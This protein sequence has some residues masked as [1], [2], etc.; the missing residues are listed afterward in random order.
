MVCCFQLFVCLGSK[1]FANLLV[2]EFKTVEHSSSKASV[3][4]RIP[5]SYFFYFIR[6]DRPL[7][8]CESNMNPMLGFTRFS[9][10]FHEV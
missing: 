7:V 6:I 8:E 5:A 10:I 9:N 3:L 1:S 2:Q 4:D